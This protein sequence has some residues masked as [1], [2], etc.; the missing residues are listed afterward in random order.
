MLKSVAL[1]KFLKPNITCSNSLFHSSNLNFEKWLVNNDKIYPPQTPD[2]PRRPAVSTNNILC[3][4]AT[5][6]LLQKIIL[7]F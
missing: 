6:T 2:E 4:V 7:L 3:I 1:F 5:V